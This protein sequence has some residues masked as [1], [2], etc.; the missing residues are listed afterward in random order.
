MHAEGRGSVLHAK[1]FVA[2]SLYVYVCIYVYM[3]I[4]IYILDAFQFVIDFVI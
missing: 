2:C 3:Y 1:N 4:S